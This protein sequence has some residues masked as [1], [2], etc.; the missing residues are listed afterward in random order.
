MAFARPFSSKTIRIELTTVCEP[1][2]SLIWCIVQHSR[3]TFAKKWTQRSGIIQRMDNSL[4]TLRGALAADRL[5]DFVRQEEAWGVPLD[6][7]SDFER[8]LALL[9]VRRRG[10]SLARLRARGNPPLYFR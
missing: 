7:G 8:A 1:G 5:E 2:F 9:V 3:E 6:S 4:L 10:Q